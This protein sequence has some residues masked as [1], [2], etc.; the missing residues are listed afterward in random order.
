M[1]GAPPGNNVGF[2]GGGVGSFSHRLGKTRAIKPNELPLD[3][4][5]IVSE[6]MPVHTSNMFVLHKKADKY[7]LGRILAGVQVNDP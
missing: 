7:Y 5:R 3:I 4:Y 1:P 6:A 2:Y